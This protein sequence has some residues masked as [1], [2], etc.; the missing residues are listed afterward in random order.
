M[1]STRSKSPVAH[2]RRKEPLEEICINPYDR[3]PISS[4]YASMIRDQ[5]AALIKRLEKKLGSEVSVRLA[6]EMTQGDVILDKYRITCMVSGGFRASQMAVIEEE[7][8][9]VIRING[10][11]AVVFGMVDQQR[12]DVRP[13]RGYDLTCKQLALLGILMLGSFGVLALMLRS[14]YVVS[15]E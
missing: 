5:R 6:E 2:T 10:S 1:S 8:D 13:L 4:Q 12:F 15:Q 14:N 9:Y 11:N 7:C 3:P